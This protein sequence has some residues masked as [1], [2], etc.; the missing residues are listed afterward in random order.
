MKLPLHIAK[1]LV[2]LMDSGVKLPSSSMKHAVVTKMLEDSALSKHQISN[3]KA[4][5]YLKNNEALSN[6]LQNNFGINDLHE[7][8]LGLENDELNRS[9]SVSISS[10]SKLKK[11]RTFKGFLVNSYEPIAGCLHN[12]QFIIQPA[13]GSFVY[14]HDYENFEIDQD[15]IVIGIENSENF[16]QIHHQQYLFPNLKILFVSRYPQSKDLIKWLQRIPNQYIHFGDFDF[17]GIAIYLNE[18]K[19]HL[20]QRATFFVPNNLENLLSQFGSRDLFN[21]QFQPTKN[22]LNSTDDISIRNLYQL[23]L[24]YKKVLEQELLIQKF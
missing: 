23:I 17:A 20:H 4:F 14:I 18:F 12:E 2:T 10:N 19:Q 9:E 24:Q 3:S 8:I 21:K 13:Q 1:C 16:S 15:V 6:Y 22:Y 5:I 11:I 7:Y